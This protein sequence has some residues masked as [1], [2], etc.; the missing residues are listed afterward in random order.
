MH[1]FLSRAVRGFG[2]SHGSPGRWG[3]R[4]RSGAGRGAFRCRLRGNGDSEG[5]VRQ[6][7]IPWAAEENPT[8]K[9]GILMLLMGFQLPRRGIPRR[10][11]ALT[12]RGA[13][14][15]NVAGHDAL[16]VHTDGNRPVLRPPGES[17]GRTNRGRRSS[18]WELHNGR[19]REA[20]VSV[21]FSGRSRRGLVYR[22][23]TPGYSVAQ[24][25]PR[26]RSDLAVAPEQRGGAFAL[27]AASFNTAALT[28]PPPGRQPAAPHLHQT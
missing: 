7:G 1:E 9:R 28:L 15:R 12:R 21:L 23:H 26:S 17:A 3:I 19:G 22:T 27:K 13:A 14:P 5:P 18:T 20:Q 2:V 6:S 8:R 10:R 24:V 25:E 16:L 4:T 11:Q